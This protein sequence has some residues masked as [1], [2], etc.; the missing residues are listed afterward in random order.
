[1]LSHDRQQARQAEAELQD[2]M[3]ALANDQQKQGVQ[4]VSVLQVSTPLRTTFMS[5]LFPHHN[6][7]LMTVMTTVQYDRQREQ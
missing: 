3:L 5:S 1:M 2:M 4:Y 6:H 7:S